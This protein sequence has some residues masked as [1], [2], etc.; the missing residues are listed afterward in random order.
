MGIDR[1]SNSIRPQI[2]LKKSNS[3]KPIV[4]RGPGWIEGFAARKNPKLLTEKPAESTEVYKF[5]KKQRNSNKQRK[6]KNKPY[7]K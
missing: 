5:Q 2:F 7:R 1:E 4:A 3:L 6:P